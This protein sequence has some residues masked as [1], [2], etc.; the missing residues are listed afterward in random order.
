MAKATANQKPTACEQGGAEKL[1]DQI[2]VKTGEKITFESWI[3]KGAG[4]VRL[5]I[6]PP[7]QL[8][9]PT[10]VFHSQATGPTLLALKPGTHW[11]LWMMLSPSDAWQW[12]SEIATTDGAGKTT[13]RVRHRMKAATTIPPALASVEVIVQ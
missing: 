4:E 8:G 6:D 13:V 9:D 5:W 12:R 7:A 10:T 2:T 1:P 3:C 11:L